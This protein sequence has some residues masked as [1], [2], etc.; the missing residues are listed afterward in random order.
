MSN[1]K[2]STTAR[3]C[4]DVYQFIEAV[5]ESGWEGEHTASACFGKVVVNKFEIDLFLCS[6]KAEVEA[7]NAPRHLYDQFREAFPIASTSTYN[8]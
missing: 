7:G 6:L 4:P 5:C 2:V 1:E 3:E 8:G